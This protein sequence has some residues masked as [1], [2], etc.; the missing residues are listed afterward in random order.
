MKFI[1]GERG[2]RKLYV[3]K[4]EIQCRACDVKQS[5]SWY[6]CK[7]THKLFCDECGPHF[8]Y[9]VCKKF[10]THEHTKVD[11]INLTLDEQEDKN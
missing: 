3:S 10:T 9:A 1:L 5:K 2:R 11:E 7:F 8:I 6:Y 4:E